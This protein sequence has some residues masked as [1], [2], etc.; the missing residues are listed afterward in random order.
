MV[1]LRE[2]TISGPTTYAAKPGHRESVDLGM[3]VIGEVSE[4]GE[5]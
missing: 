4:G 1:Y 2:V 3:K 5:F